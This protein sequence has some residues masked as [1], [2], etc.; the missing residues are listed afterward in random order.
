MENV[1]LIFKICAHW[2]TKRT[3]R[4]VTDLP[5]ITTFSVVLDVSMQMY[6]FANILIANT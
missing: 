5:R 2:I 6:I 3:L 4:V 1:Y